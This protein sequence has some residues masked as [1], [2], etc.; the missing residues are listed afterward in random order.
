LEEWVCND[1][2]PSARLSKA[3]PMNVIDDFDEFWR[4]LLHY[5]EASSCLP[6][7]LSAWIKLVRCKEKQVA[8]SIASVCC[9]LHAGILLAKLFNPENGGDIFSRNVG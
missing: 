5:S 9:P 6:G 3:Q 2:V 1:N 7:V 8:R 4:L